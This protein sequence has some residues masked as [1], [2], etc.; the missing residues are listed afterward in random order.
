LKDH[1]PA[2]T[3]DLSTGHSALGVDCRAAALCR[4]GIV[5]LIGYGRDEARDPDR[6]H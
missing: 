1:P 4:E 2:A 6:L 5:N 3:G